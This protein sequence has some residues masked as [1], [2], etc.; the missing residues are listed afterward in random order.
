MQKGRYDEAVDFLTDLTC[1]EA[2]AKKSTHT[3]NSA[4]QE[5]LARLPLDHPRRAI[6]ES[7]YAAIRRESNFLVFHHKQLFQVLWNRCRWEAAS[8]APHGEALRLLLDQW[9]EQVENRSRFAWLE[10]VTPPPPDAARV[11]FEWKFDGSTTE[12]FATAFSPNGRLLAGGTRAGTIYLWDLV[13]EGKPRMMDV[14]DFVFRLVFSPDGCF[15]GAT[16]GTE[17]GIVV[18]HLTGEKVF[19][20]PSGDGK[21][22]S[23]AFSPDG[24]LLAAGGSRAE[25][26]LWDFG[27]GRET[28]RLQCPLDDSGYRWRDDPDWENQVT[29]LSFSPD[30]RLLAAALG[31]GTGRVCLWELETGRP[32]EFDIRGTLLWNRQE[33]HHAV[34]DFAFSPD[35]RYLA[36][37]SRD[38]SVHLW[39]TRSTANWSQ[40]MGRE[41]ATRVVFTSDGRYLAIGT[42]EGAVRLWDIAGDDFGVPGEDIEL[43]RLVGSVVA[44]T[45]LPEGRLLVSTEDVSTV[46]VCEM[47]WE[48]ES[49][50]EEDALRMFSI[51]FSPDNRWL[52]ST[53]DTVRLWD[54]EMGVESSRLPEPATRLLFS[55]D[56][57][58]LVALDGLEQT[59][60]VWDLED[61][62]LLWSQAPVEEVA[63]DKAG[64]LFVGRRDGSVCLCDLRNGDFLG[65]SEEDIDEL[66][67][68]RQRKRPW[69]IYRSGG[70]TILHRPGAFRRNSSDEE[71]P[72]LACLPVRLD[73]AT[74]SETDPCLI[75][76]LV[77]RHLQIFRLR[78]VTQS[79]APSS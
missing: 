62:T 34:T 27:T 17:R 41:T 42:W 21:F 11:T 53:G 1:L 22:Y 8:G 63:F 69:S 58:H 39:D 32:E 67:Y 13:G 47:E 14:G 33:H 76:G 26:I 30:G 29:K 10:A 64:S 75:A 55:A 16:R 68:P 15:L 51:D 73:E 59:V 40:P 77:E 46:C 36:S 78:G 57:R 18:W 6:V 74:I 70:E 3:L 60:H 31:F 4:F 61:L 19:E 12:F 56:S 25:I 79:A 52:A 7:L 5:T 24:Q 66:A 37:S 2:M 35:S 38:E 71:T 49:D 44:L 48:Q 9:R 72:P 43:G 23:L 20:V 45:F 50:Q 54:I 65:W 28:G